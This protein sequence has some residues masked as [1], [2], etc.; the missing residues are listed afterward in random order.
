MTVPLVSIVSPVYNGEKYL[1]NCIQGVLNQSY[2]NFEYIVLDNA[3]TDGTSQIIEGFAHQDSRVKVYRNSSTLKIIDNWNESLKYTSPNAEWIKFAFA[4]DYLFPNCVEE[5]VRVGEH[6]AS[7]GFVSAYH[8]NGKLVAN[9]G[10][11]LQQEIADGT[12]ML[13]KHIRRKLHVCLDS[14]NTVCYRKSVLDEM[15]GFD[16]TYFHADTELALRI[17]SRYN[18]GFVHQVLTWTGVNED[19]GANFAF[20][21]GLITREYLK[22]AYQNIDSYNGMKLTPD[23]LKEVSKYYAD[24]I[25]RYVSAHLVHSLFKEIYCLWSEAPPGVKK[26]IIPAVGKKWPVYMKKFLGSILHYRNRRQNR[27]TFKG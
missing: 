22:F 2:P 4:D 7:I 6:D 27:P 21:H 15:G 16:N 20:Y 19:R 25:A 5:M 14:P 9:V 26:Q 18:L 24:E 8:L 12:D 1:E 11:P 3:S 13:K 17:L 10:L 23:E